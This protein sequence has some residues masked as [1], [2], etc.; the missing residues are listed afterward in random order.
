MSIILNAG[1]V[2]EMQALDFQ[3]NTSKVKPKTVKKT[4]KCRFFF[5]SSEFGVSEEIIPMFLQPP[6]RLSDRK[7][8]AF[9]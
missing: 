2:P 1:S 4:G 9:L 3:E 8:H 5:Y 6:G 7:L